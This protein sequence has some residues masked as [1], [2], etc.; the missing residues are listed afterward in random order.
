MQTLCNANDII[1]RERE[2]KTKKKQETHR[3]M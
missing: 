2:K 1:E 3:E